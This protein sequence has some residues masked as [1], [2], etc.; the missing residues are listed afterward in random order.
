MTSPAVAVRAEAQYVAAGE[1]QALAAPQRQPG[2]AAAPELIPRV[3]ETMPSA[4]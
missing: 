2:V 4:A 1:R 3:P